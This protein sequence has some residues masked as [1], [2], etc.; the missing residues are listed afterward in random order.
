MKTVYQLTK[1]SIGSGISSGYPHVD[2]ELDKEVLSGLDEL[3]TL[4]GF[5]RETIINGILSVEVNRLNDIVDE[6]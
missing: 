6:K 2:L 1:E 3:C 4:Y 5:D